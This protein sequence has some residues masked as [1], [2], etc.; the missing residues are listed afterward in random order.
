[1]AN[2]SYNMFAVVSLQDCGLATVWDDHLCY[3]LTPALSAYETERLTG[4]YTVADTT[5]SVLQMLLFLLQLCLCRKLTDNASVQLYVLSEVQM[6]CIW[7][8]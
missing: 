7:L 4:R 3:I 1:M 8:S 5:S 6:I 2:L